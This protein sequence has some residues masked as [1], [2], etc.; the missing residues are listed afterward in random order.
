[1]VRPGKAG[2]AWCGEARQGLARLGKAWQAW[3]YE[4]RQANK[5]VNYHLAKD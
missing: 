1:M 3:P 5:Q 2:V 4:A